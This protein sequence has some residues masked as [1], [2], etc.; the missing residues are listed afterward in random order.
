[1]KNFTENRIYIEKHQMEIL[2][3]KKTIH[4]KLRAE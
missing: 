1:M 4:P 3:M 2:E